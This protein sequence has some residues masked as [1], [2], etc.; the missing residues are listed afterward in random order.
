MVFCPNRQGIVLYSPVRG[1]NYFFHQTGGEIIFFMI[2]GDN[3]FSSKAI[4]AD[5]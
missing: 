1:R 4:K 5:Q 3:L 2:P